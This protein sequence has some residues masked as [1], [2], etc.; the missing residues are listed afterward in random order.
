LRSLAAKKEEQLSEP[1]STFEESSSVPSPKSPSTSP[2][3]I[4][5]MQTHLFYANDIPITNE[6]VTD[7][8]NTGGDTLGKDIANK[9]SKPW[10]EVVLGGLV[11]MSSFLVAISTLPQLPPDSVKLANHL[12]DGIAWAFAMEFIARWYACLSIQP[13]ETNWVQY[14]FQ[15]YFTRPL[16][17][18]DVVVV[19][20]PLVL[21]GAPHDLVPF[22]LMN[23]S[24]LIN[25]RLL[26]ILRLQRVLVDMETFASF[27]IA[28]GLQPTDV[29]PYQLQLARVVLS[30]FTLLSVSTGLI[31]T[32]EHTANPTMFPDYFTALY[33][34]LT[35]LTTVGFGDI[36]PITWEGRLV[37]SGSILAGVA[38]IP[39][40]AA[41]L[42]EALLEFQNEKTSS[43]AVV[44]PTI[45]G[46][47]D[48]ERSNH[49]K[50]NNNSS[51]DNNDIATRT[52]QNCGTDRH[53]WKEATFCWSCGSRQLVSISDERKGSTLN[54]KL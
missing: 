9:L 2:Q 39:A 34:G 26:R 10:V 51:G 48:R 1:A 28:L 50:G 31:Y 32:A 37:V 45:F 30:V 14:S 47:N 46:N 18:L 21:N 27:E 15:K 29:R 22:W 24:G 53:H 43:G 19:M 3:S 54:N 42:V 12:E 8:K 11:L 25:L 35:T 13:V 36:T 6:A 7:A 16:V 40:Q 4:P 41:A 17:A 5:E 33:F 20:L 23:S 38:I 52:C 44:A 49:N